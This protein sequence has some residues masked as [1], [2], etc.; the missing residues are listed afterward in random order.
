MHDGRESTKPGLSLCRSEGIIEHFCRGLATNSNEFPRTCIP[1]IPSAKCVLAVSAQSIFCSLDHQWAGWARHR[2]QHQAEFAKLQHPSEPGWKHTE[3][4]D[5]SWS[6]KAIS[7]CKYS[8]RDASSQELRD[9]EMS[10]KCCS[11]TRNGFVLLLANRMKEN[12]NYSHHLQD[13]FGS[14]HVSHSQ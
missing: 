10:L 7:N 2:E 4:A 6:A 1:F 13:G 5:C 11:L 9:G 12:N 8:A 3:A 14:N